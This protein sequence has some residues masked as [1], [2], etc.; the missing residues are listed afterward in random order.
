MQV[1]R[2]VSGSSWVAFLWYAKQTTA[3]ALPAKSR[4]QGLCLRRAGCRL[5]LQFRDKGED[6]S[7]S[8][9]SPLSARGKWREHFSAWDLC[10]RL[11]E[12][13]SLPPTV[14]K[15][16][17]QAVPLCPSHRRKEMTHFEKYFV[18]TCMCVY[19]N[20]GVH[21]PEHMWKSALVHFP[22]CL[23][24]TLLSLFLYARLACRFPEIFLFLPPV[25]Q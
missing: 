20:V 16:K 9:T 7:Y 12:S 4:V 25:L 11:R 19:T 21:M 23:G 22:P 13:H 15:T 10:S 17:M 3:G 1:N 5:R 14:N 8:L 6:Q 18:C 24:H 2:N